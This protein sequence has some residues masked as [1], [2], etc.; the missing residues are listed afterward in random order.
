MRFEVFVTGIFLFVRLPNLSERHLTK[1]NLQERLII[2]YISPNVAASI[3]EC[4]AT[5]QSYIYYGG[6]CLS[7]VNL[8]DVELEH[9]AYESQSKLKFRVW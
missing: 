1:L 3:P 9:V 4:K 8:K 2:N 6:T 5:F 7:T